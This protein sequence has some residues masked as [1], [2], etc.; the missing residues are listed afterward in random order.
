MTDLIELFENSNQEFLEN[1][2][3]LILSGVSERAL[4]GSLM[5]ILE[6]NL[7]YTKYQ[8]YYI[9]V[10]YNR[11]NGRIKTIIDDEMTIIPICCDLIIHSRGEHVERDNLI[12]LEMKKST[13]RKEDKASD[14]KRLMALTKDTFHDAWSYD[15]KTLP[16]HV[17]RYS[18]GVFYEINMLKRIVDIE[19]YSKGKLSKQYKLRF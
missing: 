19:Y 12:A 13:A 6:N 11:N 10:E 1:E 17:C 8:D 7:E 15:G 14:K 2:K 18:L 16:E 3:D 5:K 9:D 4:C